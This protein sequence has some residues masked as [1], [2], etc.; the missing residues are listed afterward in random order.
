MSLKLLEKWDESKPLQSVYSGNE[1]KLLD[2]CLML[3]INSAKRWIGVYESKLEF[4]KRTKERNAVNAKIRR[5]QETIQTYENYREKI[6]ASVK[7][8]PR[9]L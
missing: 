3:S 4:L 8:K 5:N 9:I 6:A 2:H 1:V 7:R